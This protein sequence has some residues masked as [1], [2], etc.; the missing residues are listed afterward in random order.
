MVTP[1]LRYELDEDRAVLALHGELDDVA[2]SE[3]RTAIAQGSRELT[4]D[5]RIDL[6]DVSFMPSPAIGVL[7]TSQA[8]ARRNGATIVLVAPEGSVAARLLT[9]C[10]LDYVTGLD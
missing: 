4:A 9:I 10:A 5:L 3:L 8:E 6:S 2:S 7:A 1:A